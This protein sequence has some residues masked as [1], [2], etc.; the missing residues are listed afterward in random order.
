MWLPCFPTLGWIRQ[1]SLWYTAHCLLA[2]LLIAPAVC[3]ASGLCTHT[4]TPFV[5]ALLALASPIPQSLFNS[6]VPPPPGSAAGSAANSANGHAHPTQPQT[7]NGG[8]HQPQPPPTPGL[9][10]LEVA[11][12]AYEILEPLDP[13]DSELLLVFSAL[14]RVVARVSGPGCE[15]AVVDIGKWA[16]GLLLGR[17]AHA[18]E[19]GE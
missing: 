2:Y 13:R 11:K 1:V 16:V 5:I 10:P 7:A 18:P 15:E 19:V 4:Y 8:A 6:H 14:M 3:T 17:V 12:Q 9:A